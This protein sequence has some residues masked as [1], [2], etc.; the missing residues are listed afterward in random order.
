M[1]E[2]KGTIKIL[3]NNK[4]AGH[5]YFLEKPIEA[6]IEL[7]GTEVKSI[8]QGK[9]SIKEAYVF[10]EGGEAFIDGMHISPYKEGNIYNVDPIRTRKLLLHKKE[11]QKL[12]QAVQQAGYSILPLNV[13]LKEGLIKVDIALGRGKKLYD[14]R[15]SL[16]REDDRRK[17]ER[18]IR[19]YKD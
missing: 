6:G 9:V 5:D 11:I 1:A 2:K 17:V 8:R 13:H 14:K 12:G 19:Q 7:R 18:A 15:E 10:V 4:R 16:K 3:A